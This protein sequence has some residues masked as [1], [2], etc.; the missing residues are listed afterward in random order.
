MS[1]TKFGRL[2]KV[3]NLKLNLSNY[4]ETVTKKVTVSFCLLSDRQ[5][6]I[7]RS[8][9]KSFILLPVALPFSEPA[10]GEH[11]HKGLSL[12][13]R[14]VVQKGSRKGLGIRKSWPGPAG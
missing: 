12:P 3:N 1:G 4:E 6:Q 2:T 9:T 13:R 11:K 7:K 5:M 8:R 10:T 14:S